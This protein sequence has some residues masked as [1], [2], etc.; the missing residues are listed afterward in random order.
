MTTENQISVC[1]I[2]KDNTSK[3]I[4]KME[5]QI[6]SQFQIYSDIYKE[7]LHVLDDIFGACLLSEKE[8]FDKMNID[9]KLLKNLKSYSDNLSEIMINQIENYDNYLKWYSQVRISG[10]KSYD[11]FIHNMM[12]SYSKMLLMYP[13]K[14]WRQY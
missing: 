11:Q 12:D 8:F 2:F 13:K 3:I 7:Y 1:N 5:M 9:E 4:K 10:M 14:I 6:P